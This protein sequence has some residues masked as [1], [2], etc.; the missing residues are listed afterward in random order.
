MSKPTNFDLIKE[1]ILALKD[2]T[3]SSPAAIKVYLGKQHPTIT[4]DHQFLK[5]LQTGV[6]AGKLI[7][8]RT[9]RGGRR[10]WFGLMGWEGEDGG[11]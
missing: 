7:K 9:T 5:A 2:R 8:V 1:A 4:L 3:G 10:G 6:T 11:S